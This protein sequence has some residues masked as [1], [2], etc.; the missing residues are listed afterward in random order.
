[1][2]TLPGRCYGHC[3]KG[4]KL[5]LKQVSNLFVI[6][7]ILE[8]DEMEFEPSSLKHF[9]VHNRKIAIKRLFFKS[10]IFEK[11]IPVLRHSFRCFLD[12]GEK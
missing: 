2:I 8:T 9:S 1:M 6:N 5:K 12:E 7:K 3:F 4:I 10:L 11:K